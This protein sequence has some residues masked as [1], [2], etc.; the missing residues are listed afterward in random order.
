MKIF[1]RIF[2]QAVSGTS[3]VFQTLVADVEP[4][5]ICGTILNAIVTADIW[6]KNVKKVGVI[7]VTRYM[8]FTRT[9]SVESLN[10]VMANFHGLSF[11]Y[12]FTG[13]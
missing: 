3:N 4:A 13:T 8:Y 12:R 2:G 10:F 6:G 11:L 5:Q 7:L 1:L 9:C